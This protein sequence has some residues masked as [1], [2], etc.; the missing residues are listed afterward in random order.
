MRLT[1]VAF[2]LSPDFVPV[3]LHQR[4]HGYII[5]QAS[6]KVPGS[7]NTQEGIITVIFITEPRRLKRV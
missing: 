4:G 6:L 1:Q 7:N 5:M 3:D 2:I